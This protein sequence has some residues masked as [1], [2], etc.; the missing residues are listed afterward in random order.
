MTQTSGRGSAAVIAISLLWTKHTFVEEQERQK[1]T[2][3]SKVNRGQHCLHRISSSLPSSRL[4]K[5]LNDEHYSP[6]RLQDLKCV[7]QN[8]VVC[9]TY[10]AFYIDIWL[11]SLYFCFPCCLFPSRKQNIGST[12]LLIPLLKTN[13]PFTW[14]LLMLQWCAPTLLQ[15]DLFNWFPSNKLGKT[16]TVIY[17]QYVADDV[18]TVIHKA[19]A[20]WYAAGPS[21]T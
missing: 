21:M 2:R 20:G 15:S 8:R 17:C 1:R 9:R 3:E 10:V 11:K 14:A 18:Y 13:R 19:L 7:W 5:L 16:L 4:H 6:V 12:C